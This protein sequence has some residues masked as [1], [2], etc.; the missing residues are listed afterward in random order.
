MPAVTIKTIAKAAGVSRG[1]VDRVL[2]DRG[3]VRE[4]I[5]LR[6]KKLA[7][8]L[9]YVPNRAGRALS[10]YRSRYRIG[11][12]LPS[13]GNIFFNDVIK[14][15]EQAKAEYSD[16]GLD[17]C[18]KQIQGFDESVH[19]EAI[20][21]LCRD[22]FK[23]LCLTTINTMAVSDR[24]NKC[25]S[26]GIR[27]ILLN[28]D[29]ENC[30]RMCYVGSDYFKAGKT[31]G[32]ML[33]LIS[34]FK[35]NHILI[36]TGSSLSLGQNLRIKGFIDELHRL[37]VQFDTV[38]VVE[39]Q[40]SDIEAQKVT[41]LALEKNNDINCIFISGAGVQGV[42]AA[43]INSGRKDLNVIAFDDTYSTKELI[44]AGIIRFVVCQQPEIQGYQAVR[45]AYLALCG[46]FTEDKIADFYTETL[47]K[48]RS[49]LT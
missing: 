44:R 35:M 42:G 6:V 26:D 48:I 19:L 12:L 45:L 39:C 1:T 24:I 32:G 31:C 5:A 22:G 29:V 8:D 40:D 46:Q 43:L 27:V 17:I 37:G 21:S 10:S 11:V 9:G 23:A 13:I 20:D 30:N 33:S 14:G 3:Y 41:T 2:H 18:I 16:L 28:N 38:A 7:L 36:V 4:E 47:I 49:N 25:M 15:I 34:G